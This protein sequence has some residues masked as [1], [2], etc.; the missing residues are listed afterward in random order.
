MQRGGALTLADGRPADALRLALAAG[1]AALMLP[2]A[3]AHASPI[4]KPLPPLPV[5]GPRRVPTVTP[6]PNDELGSG[7]YIEANELIDDE[8]QHTVTAKGEVEARY[9]GRVL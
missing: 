2:A 1:A 5:Y 8:Q 3:L 9:Q 4:E 6:P 7:F